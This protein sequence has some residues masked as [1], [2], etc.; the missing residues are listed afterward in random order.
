MPGGL[1]LIDRRIQSRSIRRRGRWA[2]S[3]GDLPAAEAA[4]R[5][6]LGSDATAC[7]REHEPGRRIVGPGPFWRGAIGILRTVAGEPAVASHWVNLGTARRG[8]RE[9]DQ[10][11]QAYAAAA[12]LGENEAEFYFNVGVRII[13]RGD[14]ESAR[15]FWIRLVNLIPR[16]AEITFVMPTRAIDRFKTTPRQQRSLIWR[17]LA[18]AAPSVLRRSP[19][20]SSIWGSR[21]KAKAR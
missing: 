6:A 19:S 11:L 8:M 4:S 13:D 2:L 7:V 18:S 17:C 9:Y 3:A 10:A 21:R 20:C 15:P 5:K 14:F 16:D 12:R 1:L